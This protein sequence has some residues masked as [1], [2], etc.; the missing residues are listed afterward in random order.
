MKSNSAFY[1]VDNRP[2]T[3]VQRKMQE[4]ISCSQVIQR[5]NIKDAVIVPLPQAAQGAAAAPAAPVPALGHAF[6]ATITGGPYHWA[7]GVA[8][9]G[10]RGAILA[11][12]IA[13]PSIANIATGLRKTAAET[14][15]GAP[16]MNITYDAALGGYGLATTQN[17]G[18]D[19]QEINITIGPGAYAS[20]ALLYST[21]RHELIHAAQA[22]RTD[23][24]EQGWGGN[25]N[26]V[27][28]TDDVEFSL[29]SYLPYA[30]PAN[31]AET[32][33]NLFYDDMNRALSEMETHK[34][35][36]E[37][38]P[39]TGL[40]AAL[41]YERGLF[42]LSY[43]EKWNDLTAVADNRKTSPD[44]NTHLL[45]RVRYDEYVA[46]AAALTPAAAS[47][48]EINN[49]GLVTLNLTQAQANARRVVV[50]A[51][52]DDPAWNN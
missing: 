43:Y 2:G 46:H 39:A 38:T 40:D 18:Q 32:N 11:L 6:D 9:A 4:A 26:N 45:T 30:A 35:E 52:R 44:P 21:I 24:K 36:Y 1:L 33:R 48:T 5:I 10:Q 29:Y 13:E 47:I 41:R 37:N 51:H 20:K 25:I 12:M 28:G 3:V 49:L 17:H 14:G 15:G 50:D 27:S 19:W 42:W 31:Q 23:A 7:A 8:P 34:W 16:D 22:R